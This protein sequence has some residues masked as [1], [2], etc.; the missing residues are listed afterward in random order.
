L[1][2]V[3]HN[4]SVIL[5]H[6]NVG[7]PPP[8]LNLNI[9]SRSSADTCLSAALG[10][11]QITAKFLERVPTIVAPQFALCT[12]IAGRAILAHSTLYHEKLDEVA[13]RLLDSLRE[14]S[15]RWKGTC[16][17]NED[18]AGK[19]AE[20]FESARKGYAPLDG[21]YAALEENCFSP[22]PISFDSPIFADI[23]QGGP[24]LAALSSSADILSKNPITSGFPVKNGNEGDNVF[25]WDEC[26]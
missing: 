12:F 13:Q 2:H 9:P 23:F 10:I 26:S 5:L 16:Y 20:K 11:S 22:P 7:Y 8:D 21:R 18:L 14:M 24:D 3:T 17:S 4:A 19:F 1:A 15:K 6:H 25:F